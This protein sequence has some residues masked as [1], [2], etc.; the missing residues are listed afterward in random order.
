MRVIGRLRS[1]RYT[2]ALG[3]RGRL[4]AGHPQWLLYLSCERNRGSPVTLSTNIPLP[5][6]ESYSLSKGGSVPPF[7][8]DGSN[9]LS[10]TCFIR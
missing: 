4:N 9:T 1:S 5:N 2:M 6:S 7:Y 3:S 8:A 10:E